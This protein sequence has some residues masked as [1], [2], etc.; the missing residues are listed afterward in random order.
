M[1]K[2]PLFEP[3]DRAPHCA[4]SDASAARTKIRMSNLH[5]EPGRVSCVLNYSPIQALC[6]FVKTQKSKVSLRARHNI[7]S[8]SKDKQLNCQL[9]C[10][11]LVIQR[12]EECL[13]LLSALISVSLSSDTF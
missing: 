7:Y 9:V 12:T 10:L 4:Y 2:I 11:V 13:G 5:W 6:C 3:N 8:S 1:V